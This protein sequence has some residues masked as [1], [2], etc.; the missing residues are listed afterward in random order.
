MMARLLEV[1]RIEKPH[2]VRGEAIVSLL[3]N[4]QERVAVGSR[5]SLRDGRT[6]VITESRPHTG[7]WI[8]RFDGVADRNAVDALH[9]EALFAEP[10]DDPDALWIHELIG[11]TVVDARDGRE[12]G[13]VHAVEENPASDLLVLKGSGALVPLRF[14]VDHDRDRQRI[15]VDVPEGLLELE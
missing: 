1:G 3:T 11:A 15:T 12:L 10:I 8:V 6:L 2:G 4:R 7:R 13:V 14:V 9:G 5:L